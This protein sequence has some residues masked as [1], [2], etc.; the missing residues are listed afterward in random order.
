MKDN[1]KLDESLLSKEPSH[2]TYNHFVEKLNKITQDEEIVEKLDELIGEFMG[3]LFGL[4]LVLSIDGRGTKKQ[5][6]K[7]IQRVLTEWT[8]EKFED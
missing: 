1:L 3:Y 8:G 5:A 6:S 7:S 4:S 2:S